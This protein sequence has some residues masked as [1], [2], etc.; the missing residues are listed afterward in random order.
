[1]AQAYGGQ[2]VWTLPNDAE[3]KLDQDGFFIQQDMIAPDVVAAINTEL[4]EWRS[5]PA[6]NGYGCIFQEG[7]AL[8][9]NV[10]LYSRVALHAVL[11]EQLLDFMERYYGEQPLLS[12]FEF[13]RVILPKPA[14]PLHTDNNKDISIFIYLNGVSTE[15]GATAVALG[16]HKVGV[17]ENNGR[18]Q[19]PNDVQHKYNFPIVEV[20]G[21]PG[22]CLVANFDTW[23]LRTE[24][25]VPG[26]EIIWVTYTPVSRH[27]DCMEIVLSR[28]ALLGL[29][30]KQLRALGIGLAP[31]KGRRAEDF[32]MSRKFS[33][34][35][36]QMLSDRQLLDAFVWRYLYRL[37]AATPTWV[38]Q[39]LKSA[40]RMGSR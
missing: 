13:R 1:M 35:S 29:S 38:K 7:D 9:Q 27:V 28:H 21:G 23:H 25:S 5:V 30:E 24:T 34:A 31:F 8:L 18:L 36:L 16:S 14:M 22:V 20:K 37:K 17:K 3:Q 10:A 39:I 26:R 33:G 12:K 19:V 6:I 11:N 15:T 32:A 40:L 2:Q 4:E